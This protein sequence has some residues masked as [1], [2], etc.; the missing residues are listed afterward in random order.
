MTLPDPTTPPHWRD[1]LRALLHPRVVTLLF[2][3]FS[4]GLPLLLIFSSLSLWLREVGVERSVVTLFSW[5]ALGYS[6]KFV[7]APLVDALPLPLLGPRLGRRRSWM[8]FSQL[9]VITAIICMALQD[10]MRGPYALAYMSVFAVMLGFSAAT[11]D[12]VIDAY[13]IESAEPR[14]QAL[15]SSSYIAGYRVGMLVAGAGV[16]FLA[17]YYGS[18]TENYHYPAWRNAYLWMALAMGVGVVAT[19]VIA[20]PPAGEHAVTTPP[21]RSVGHSLQ[22]MRLFV[23]SVAGFVLVYALTA[24]A[25]GEFKVFLGRVLGVAVAAL[26][27]EF[28]R[29]L[30]A[31][32]FSALVSKSLIWLGWV[33]TAVVTQNYLQ[34]VMDFFER[35]GRAT[36]WLL[37]LLICVYRI[38]DIVLGVISNVFYQDLG[39]TKIEIATVSKSYGLFMSIAGGF[40]GGAL[41]Y[42]HGVIRIL[43]LGALLA[44]FTN[45]LFLA[46]TATGNNLPMLYI[47]I[48]A[49][50]LAAG[51]ASAAFVAFLSALT[52]IRFT[53]VQYALFTSLMTLLPK[54]LGGYAGAMVDTLGYNRFFLLT[55]VLG[56]PALGLIHLARLR[57]KVAG[58]AGEPVAGAAS[59]QSGAQVP[60][61]GQQ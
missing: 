19:L 24:G 45:L 8:L 26:S 28:L 4:S 39:F 46:L 27:V 60:Q 18:T 22:L 40:V 36:A 54:A 34:P 12:I 50:N 51:L 56:L 11:Q 10:P 33:D 9:L 48:S 15:M 38:S 1:T 29:L 55:T 2:L 58:R 52:N 13:R 61:R 37:L 20:E 21:D 7:W 23:L 53:A 57:L 30:L 42:R 17:S 32:G 25:A 49:D 6:F 3:G 41:A 59:K 16:L 43:L 14:L 5:A 47:V 35:Y 31:L 44:A